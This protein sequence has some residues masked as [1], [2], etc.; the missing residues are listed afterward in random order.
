LN[1]LLVILILIFTP[2]VG[3]SGQSFDRYKEE[4]FPTIETENNITYGKSTAV[5]GEE[6]ELLLDLYHP[7]SDTAKMRPLIIFI[8]GGGFQNGDKA[9]KLSVRIATSMAKRGYVVANINYRLS[10]ASVMVDS[11]KYFESLYRGVQDAR[12]SI[13][14]LKKNSERF[15][16]DR[17]HIFIMGSSAGAKIALHTA[18]MDQN[19]VPALIDTLVYGT[20][21]YTNG[22][23]GGL[24]R[25]S[26]VINCWGAMW[27]WHWIQK[28]DPPV[29]SVH[30]SNDRLVP[31]DSS[32]SYNGFKYGSTIIHQRAQEL[33]IQSVLRIFK[34]SGHTLD[35]DYVRL[36][37][38]I[39]EAS[40]WLQSQINGDSEIEIMNNNSSSGI[41]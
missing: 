37:T 25:V 18:Y 30:G 15:G 28:G 40:Q 33:H 38:A 9:S 27:D 21:E 2:T 39:D 20:L 13:R 35:N 34:D 24:S 17:G 12:A 11:L 31:V 14:F 36:D 23:G 4:I 7:A 5:T 32:F 41:H 19:E 10:P 22:E 26:G 6:Y 16:V 8:H 29:F 1:Q 3:L